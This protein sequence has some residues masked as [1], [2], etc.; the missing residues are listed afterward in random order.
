MAQPFC[1]SPQSGIVCTVAK[2]D[3]ALVEHLRLRERHGHDVAVFLEAALAFPHDDG[4]D[5]QP[6]LV[7][8]VRLDQGLHQHGAAFE[9]DRAAVFF[10]SCATWVLP[11]TAT[12]LF[13][14]AC[15]SVDETT[16]L[17]V[18]LSLAATRRRSA[19]FAWNLA[20]RR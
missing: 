13:Q 19:A 15:L 11:P 5:Q 10:F 4:V 16:Y 12:E 14:S 1:R 17:G 18:L 9:Q 20:A 6:Q 7:D 3:D 2:G 8:E